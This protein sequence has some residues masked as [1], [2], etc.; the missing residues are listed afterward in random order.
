MEKERKSSWIVRMER[1][2]VVSVVAEN[3]TKEQARQDPFAYVDIRD[4]EQEHEML[5]FEVLAVRE[6]V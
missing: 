2:I 1:T 5:N 6:N 3:C 4:Q